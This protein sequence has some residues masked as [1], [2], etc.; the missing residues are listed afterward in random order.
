M[1]AAISVL[2]VMSYITLMDLAIPS[3]F[4]SFL[5]CLESVHNFNKWFPNLFAYIFPPSKLDMTS[6]SEQFESRGFDNRQ[7]LYLCGS[8]LLILTMMGAF[9][10]ILAP[11]ANCHSLFK[12]LLNKLRFSSITRSFVQAYLKICL[13]ACVNVGIVF[14]CINRT[15]NI[16]FI[17][18][19]QQYSVRDVLVNFGHADM[20][21]N[22]VPMLAIGVLV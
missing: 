3:N 2:Q 21:I 18:Q 7:M 1:W 15:N 17:V 16:F 14:C 11:L 22:S 8:D 6:Y 9:I 12:K 4:L 10:A 19:I 13:A 20:R 5:E